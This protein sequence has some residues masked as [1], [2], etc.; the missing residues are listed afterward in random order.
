MLQ[1]LSVAAAVQTTHTHTP[2]VYM[3]RQRAAGNMKVLTGVNCT[4]EVEND[5]RVDFIYNKLLSV[6]K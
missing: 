1:V 4:K 2:A 6:G 5:R 3:R